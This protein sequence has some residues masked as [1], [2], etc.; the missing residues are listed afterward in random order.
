[1]RESTQIIGASPTSIPQT[2]ETS[3]A[4]GA[5]LN[6]T[7]C[8]T[9]VIPLR[10][11]QWCGTS[12]RGTTHLVPRSMALVSPP[13]CLDRWNL[14]SRLRRCSKVSLATLRTA[15]CPILAKTAFR[16]SEKRVAPILAA[17]SGVTRE[18]SP[19]NA[20]ICRHAELTAEDERA[21]HNPH[22]FTRSYFEIKGVYYS[23]KQCRDLDV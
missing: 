19:T 9:N 17:P 13:V 3:S 20:K 5:I 2:N 15:C 10:K 1:V 4:V 12:K 6:N 7:D 21:S 8:R 16:S 14:R 11:G 23:F 22:G 18:I